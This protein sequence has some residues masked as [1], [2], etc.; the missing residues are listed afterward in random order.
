MANE[1][2]PRHYPA[3]WTEQTARET[4]EVIALLEQQIRTGSLT[5]EQLQQIFDAVPNAPNPG[6]AEHAELVARLRALQPHQLPSVV[7]HFFGDDGD[8]S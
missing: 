6:P 4:D 5:L 7:F 2:G 1:Y 3:P 8:L